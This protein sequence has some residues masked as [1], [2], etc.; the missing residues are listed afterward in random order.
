M[1]VILQ[2]SARD[3]A[4]AAR[5]ALENL[6]DASFSHNAQADVADWWERNREQYLRPVAREK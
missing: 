2:T 3:V 4:N 5:H 6:A 1:K